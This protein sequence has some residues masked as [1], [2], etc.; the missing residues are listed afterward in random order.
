MKQRPPQRVR[1]AHT[2]VTPASLNHSPSDFIN[3]L[4][5]CYVIN[6]TDPRTFVNLHTV[7]SVAHVQT[8]QCESFQPWSLHLLIQH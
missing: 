3:S 5:N 2:T 8:M 6:S 4:Y 1:W 7:L